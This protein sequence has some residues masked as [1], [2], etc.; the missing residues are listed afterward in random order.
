MDAPNPVT[1][2][3]SCGAQRRTRSDRP[4]PAA[5]GQAAQEWHPAERP[6]ALAMPA[7]ACMHACTMRVT[8]A[9]ACTIRVTCA[10]ARAVGVAC[11][12]RCG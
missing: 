5:C 4:R 6:R 10:H 7:V 12:G 3:K 11:K 2:S 1:L 8:G 9:Q